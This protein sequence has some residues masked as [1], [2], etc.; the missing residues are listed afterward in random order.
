MD[1]TN[2][3]KGAALESVELIELDV[4]EL[5]QVGGGATYNVANATQS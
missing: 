4:F 3:L 1:S 5:A 2:Q